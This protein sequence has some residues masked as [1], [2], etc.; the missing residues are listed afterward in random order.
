MGM[1]KKGKNDVF[2]NLRRKAERKV[3]RGVEPLQQISKEEA[4]KTLHELHAHQ[5]E[6]EMQNEELRRTQH[7]LEESRGKYADLYDF[8]PIGYFTLDKDGIITEANL[9]GCQMLDI[10]RQNLIN[11]QFYLFVDKDSQNTFYMHRR[12]S[13]TPGLPH[14]CEIAL[15]RNNGYRFEARL[16]STAAL[17]DGQQVIGSRVA[18]INITERKHAEA[19]LHES[20][21]R[22]HTFFE[23]SLDAVLLSRPYGSIE[24][25]NAAAC[26]MFQM[27]A[28]ELRKAGRSGIVDKSD[29]RLAQ[30]LEQRAQAGHF[31]GELNFMRK[32]GTV[33]PAEISSAL[34]TGAGRLARTAMVIRDV[35]ERKK[36]EESLLE[37]E[38]KFHG[39]FTTMNEA[40]VLFELIR[41]DAGKVVDCRMLDANPSVEQMTGIPPADL[42]GR[43]ITEAFPKTDKFWF[44]AYGKVETTGKPTSFER[45][46]EPL[47]RSFHTSIYKPAPGRVAVVFTDITESKKAEEALHQ[48]KE[49]YRTLAENL[50]CLVYRVHLAE[51]CR[52]EFFNQSLAELTGYMETELAMGEVCSIEQLIVAEDRDSAVE[53]VQRAIREHRPFEIE[54]RLRTKSG[55]VRHFAERGLPVYTPDGTCTHLDGV[56]FDITER[57]KA[58]DDVRLSEQRLK[59]AQTSAGAGIWDWDIS[60]SK[61]E[62]SEELF[63]LLGLDPAKDEASFESWMKFVHPD[64]RPVI[65]KQIEEAIENRTPLNSESRIVL[66]SGRVRWIHSLGDTVYDDEGKPQ[67]MSGICLDITN[68][69]KAEEA[70]RREAQILAQVH[71]CVV[72]TDL[73]GNITLWNRGAER[74]F[75]Y[76][77]DEALGQ[78][79]SLVYFDEDLPILGDDIIAPMLERSENELEVR[80]RHKS[81]REVFLHLSLSVLRDENGS[82]IEL[83]GYSLDITERKKA[84]EALRRSNKELNR[85]NRAAVGRELRMIELKK[86]VNELY[87]QSGRPP[88]YSLEFLNDE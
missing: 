33:F 53:E 47:D 20:E 43:T 45:L 60:T 64:D 4:L 49:S 28:D 17:N 27:S 14:T 19:A 39:L 9:T 8:A 37:S 79:I 15:V 3:H 11:K 73:Q 65:H 74:V 6:L 84:E 42:I 22:Y 58:E 51:P 70:M 30:F 80:C 59:L 29:P 61:L 46:F 38:E 62:W 48:E 23:G 78:H 67:R 44:D 5:I 85:F 68:R 7:E 1:T 18:V 13:L 87:S 2:K 75:G 35:T 63:D 32:D 88:Q 82:L 72:T 34:F 41:D 83:I 56:I 76:S 71:D 40:F 86:E 21:Q 36:A 26:Q 69:K 50:P 31:R 12:A 57:K 66:E 52:M 25:A 55:E 10:G 54:Y 16:D 77:A 24:E 81:G